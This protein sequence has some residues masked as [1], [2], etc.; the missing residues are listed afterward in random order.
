MRDEIKPTLQPDFFSPTSSARLLQ[1]DFF[2]P[3]SSA[4]CLLLD[5]FSPQPQA[6]CFQPV[7][8][9]PWPFIAQGHTLRYELPSIQVGVEIQFSNFGSPYHQ[10]CHL[11]GDRPQHTGY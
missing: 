5:V 7:F 3:T 8:F 1:P 10:D 11:P 4:R 9:S 2:S 6:Q